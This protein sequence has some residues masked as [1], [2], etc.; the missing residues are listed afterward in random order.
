MANE[1][2]LKELLGGGKKSEFD[3]L[4]ILRILWRKKHL[5]LIPLALSW[6]IS[7]VGLQYIPPTYLSAS[8]VA[9]ES[10]SSFTRDLERLLDEQGSRRQD[11]SELGRVRAQ[12]REQELLDEVIDYLGLD[13]TPILRQR[14]HKLAEGPLAGEDVNDIA[15]RLA[16]EEIRQRLEVRLGSQGLYNI[17]VESHDP[18]KAWILCRVITHKFVD[19]RRQ[20]EL[21]EITAKGDFSDEQVAIYKERLHRAETELERFQEAQQTTLAQG[22]PVNGA[23][24]IL[25]EEVMRSYSQELADIESQVNA[26]RTRLRETLG[27]VPTSDRILGNR[28]LRTLENKQIHTMLQ[29]LFSFLE[30]RIRRDESLT[31]V[32]EDASVGS[33]RQAYR[34]RL[35]ELADGIYVQESAMTRELITA[36]HYRL[37]LVRSFQELVDTLERYIG[38]FRENLSGQPA[39]QAELAR[40]Q[41]EVN[42][43]REFLDAFQQQSTSAQ[44]T[45]AIQASQLA[46]RIEVRAEPVRP[47]RPIKP[48]KPR[49]QLV[50][51]FL[52]LA[53]GLGLVLLT[54]MFNRSFTTVKDI[55]ETL[56]LPVLGTIPALEKGPGQAKIHRRKNTLTW[57]IAMAL[58]VVVMAGMM[59]FLE[60]LY[61]RTEFTMDSQA[62][63]EMMP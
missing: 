48:N 40:R 42:K 59:Y 15:R 8:S 30:T 32:I 24:V 14:A 10:P 44:I 41:A 11:V 47:I 2:L 13:Q 18:V 38:N 60:G 22:N 43:Y 58:F 4:A 31:E 27:L 63:E 49:L 9:I 26:A 34:E 51:L 56:G 33:D 1:E 39:Y 5:V 16:A 7:T 21:A 23:N 54:E 62:V 20:W 19:S 46:S 12:I 29:N 6:L 57:A 35:R 50:F 17:R 53:T 25:A 37:M 36:Y 61:S 28:D 45:R 3:L 52:G 55:E